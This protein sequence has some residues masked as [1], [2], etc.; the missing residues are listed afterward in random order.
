MT[1]DPWA[2]LGFGTSDSTNTTDSTLPPVE[3]MG[4]LR[5]SPNTSPKTYSEISDYFTYLN[6]DNKRDWDMYTKILGDLGYANDYNGVVA[7]A[8]LAMNWASK[9]ENYQAGKSVFDY[10]ATLPP[11]GTA[12]GGPRTQSS[13]TVN[14]SNKGDAASYINNS[15]QQFL[16]REASDKEMKAF[17]KA[18]NDMQSAN[19]SVTT[20]TTTTDGSTSSASYKTTGGF[21]AAQFADEWAKSRPDYAETFAATSFMSVVDNLIN[22]GPTLEGKVMNG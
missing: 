3:D 10:F 2:A 4:M 8:Q 12:Q 19:A 20:A 14:L 21:N 6:V 22:S 7:M 16:G 18:L 11:A 5:L 13:R 15:Y 17:Q 1:V 9:S